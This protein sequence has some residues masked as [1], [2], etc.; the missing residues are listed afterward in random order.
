[1]SALLGVAAPFGSTY[2]AAHGRGVRAGIEESATGLIGQ[3][4]R[5][6]DRPNDLDEALIRPHHAKAPLDVACRDIFSKSAG[7]PLA[8]LFGG[9]T[10]DPL[11]TISSIHAG[12]PNGMRAPMADHRARG[13]LEH[14]VKIGASLSE[15]GRH[16]LPHV[17]RRAWPTGAPVGSIWPTRM[18]QRRPSTSRGC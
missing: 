10:G 3:D 8:E 9:S 15:G 18:R 13:Y 16:L 4:P 5:R 11:P 14:S 6:V 17:L 7:L 1:M 2:V 12:P